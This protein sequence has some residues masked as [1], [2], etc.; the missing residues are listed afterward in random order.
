MSIRAAALVVTYFLLLTLMAR[1]AAG[2]SHFD[3]GPPM[4]LGDAEQGSLLMR[5]E[6]DGVYQPAPVLETEVQIRVSGL[7]A[8]ASVTQRF[9]TPTQEWLEGIYDFPLPVTAAVV[10]LRMIVGELIIE[11]SKGTLRLDGDARLWRRDFAGNTETEHTYDWNDHL[12]GG[13]CVYACNRHILD[14]WMADK[15]ANTEASAYVRN[16]IIQEAVYESAETGRKLSV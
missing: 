1:G 11:G 12:F 13:D 5:T 9:H 6:H 7:L 14:A 3:F 15:D 16:Q 8:R 4:R 2:E 10:G